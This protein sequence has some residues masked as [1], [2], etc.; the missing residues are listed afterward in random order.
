MWN[1]CFTSFI[2]KFGFVT[3]DA[4]SCIFIRENNGRKIILAIYVDDGLIAANN[5]EDVVPVI[6]H[7]CKKFNV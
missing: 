3:S 2:T 5:A 7:L 4:D 1:R 6:D